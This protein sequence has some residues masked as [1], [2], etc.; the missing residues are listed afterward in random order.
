M[1]HNYRVW[2]TETDPDVLRTALDGWLRAVGFRVLR[3]VEHQFSPV[4]YTALWLL[5]ESHLALHT[6]P[7]DG[8]GRAYVELSSCNPEKS[9]RFAALLTERYETTDA[10]EVSL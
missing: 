9:R 1:I 2:I 5:A 4:G 3:T 8:A 6:F 10:A 7:D